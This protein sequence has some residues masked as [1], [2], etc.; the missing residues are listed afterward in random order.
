VRIVENGRHWH[1]EK[2]GPP[3]CNGSTP[4]FGAVRSGFESWGRS[5]GYSGPVTSPAAVIVLAAGAGTRMRSSVPKVLHRIGGRTLLGHVLTTARGLDPAHLVAVV[6]H[7]R[8]AVAAHVAE[9][10]PAV[11]VADQD[12]VPGT[13]RAV[14]CALDALDAA[15]AGPLAGPVVVVAA[16]VPLLDTG[17]LAALLEAHGA[18]GNAVTALTTVVPDPTGY[19]RVVREGGEVVAVVEERD[20]TPEQRAITEINASIYVFDADALRTGLGAVGRD[21]A[22]GEVYLTDVLALARAAGGRVSALVAEDSIVVEGVNDRVQLATLGAELNRR[23]LE[24]WMRAGVTVVDPATTWVDVEVELAE[25]VTLLPGTQL[26]GATVV[27]TG[28]VI[29]PD[30]TLTDVE[31]GERATITRTHGSLAVIGEDATVGPFALLRPGAV[32]RERGKIGTFVEVK[33][34]EIGAGSKVPHL[35]YIGD[36]TIGE[37]TNVG[38][39]SVTVNYDG[40]HKH[41]TVIGSHARTGADNMFVAPVVIGDGAY[42]GAG[43]VVRRDV[44]PG[45]LAINQAGQRNVEGWVVDRRPGTAAA[46]AAQA[47]TARGAD[48]PQDTTDGPTD[49]EEQA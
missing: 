31:V 21:N 4:A 46:A 29:G 47:A 18:D 30:T 39:A 2:A 33:N 49:G 42:T 11:L 8:E 5:D 7:E 1:T 16:D 17:T 19:G 20:A 3:W 36:T 45:A 26:H 23:T 14:Q 44:P 12:D 35:S 22:Q 15:A 13:G 27:A 24:R 25:D 40:V 38:A 41:R 28:A 6:R 9:V 43:T 32:L 34:S 37:G 48:G 10:D